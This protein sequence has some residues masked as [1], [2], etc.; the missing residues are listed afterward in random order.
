MN[1]ELNDE[2]K[3]YNN[4]L[5][6]PI[7]NERDIEDFD[8]IYTDL[9]FQNIS[10]YKYNYL[11]EEIKIEEDEDCILFIN[12]INEEDKLDIIKN[13]KIKAINIKEIKKKEEN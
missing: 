3:W 4:I 5:N 10:L 13:D 12:E 1:F 6:I 8:K 7:N 9:N 11:N 2:I